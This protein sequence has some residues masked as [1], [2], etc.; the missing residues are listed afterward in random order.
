[1]L[2]ARMTVLCSLGVLLVGACSSGAGGGVSCPDAGPCNTGATGNTGGFGMTGGTG[3]VL[4]SGGTGGGNTGGIGNSSA[5]GVGNS[6]GGGG[7]TG[8]SGNGGGSGGGTPNP[9][10]GKACASSSE[11]GTGLSC[12]SAS[13]AAFDGA[14][15][16]KGLCTADCTS[17]ENLCAGIAANAVCVDYNGAAY[18]LEGCSFGP[19][20]Q[21]DFSAT[22]CHGR[23]EV[24][25]APLFDTAGQFSVAACVPQCNSDADCGGLEC[26]AKTGLCSSVSPTGQS[27]GEP[28]TVPDAG[29][30]SCKGN[31]TNFTHSSNGQVFLSMCT[32]GCT[33]GATPSCGWTG[34][35][36][37]PAPAACLFV[38]KTIQDNGG[39]SFG[40]QGSCGLLCNCNSD[41]KTPLLVCRPWTGPGAETNKS[42]FLKNGY[43][44]D[45][46]EAN[47]STN[48]GIA[49]P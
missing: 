8:G 30:D 41:C 46:L 31:C 20:S 43:C 24:A 9:N 48:P 21:P 15:P 18:C 19:S 2:L 37:G 13:S 6:G 49:C 5:G 11:C 35:G 47:G 26:H 16:A 36:T 32:E 33:L 38:S 42:F 44:S 45:P 28:C 7:N 23:H 22:K 1:M 4:V 10:L 27:L 25:C 34:P 39:A 40:D 12:I 17:D 3:G 29:V 14:G